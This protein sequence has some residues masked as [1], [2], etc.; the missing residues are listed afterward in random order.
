MHRMPY[1]FRSF[2]E[3]ETS[4][5]AN[6]GSFAKNDLQLKASYRSS[7]PCIIRVS[8]GIEMVHGV[9]TISRLHKIIDV[10]CRI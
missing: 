2:S 3:I 9:A 7:P 8:D 6:S 10:F 5:S 4:I 1:L